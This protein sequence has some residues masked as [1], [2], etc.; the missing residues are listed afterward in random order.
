[1]ILSRIRALGPALAAGYFWWVIYLDAKWFFQG[2]GWL[3][4]VAGAI[5]LTGKTWDWLVHPE[6]FKPRPK[7]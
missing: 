6:L 2:V 1:M 4:T 5:W 3:A 7:R